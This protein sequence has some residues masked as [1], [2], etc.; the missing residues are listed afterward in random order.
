MT[1][2]VIH[3]VMN[4]VIMMNGMLIAMAVLSILRLHSSLMKSEYSQPS[5]T[6]V[7]MPT[8][9]CKNNIRMYH[10]NLNEGLVLLPVRSHGSEFFCNLQIFMMGVEVGGEL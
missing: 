1:H 3:P 5:M 9:V 8:P 4:S 2:P 6:K 7:S 10:F